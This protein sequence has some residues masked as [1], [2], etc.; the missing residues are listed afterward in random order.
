MFTALCQTTPRSPPLVGIAVVSR[1]RPARESQ[2]SE[3]GEIVLGTTAR[4]ARSRGKESRPSLAM[5]TEPGHR[6]RRHARTPLTR[7][8]TRIGH[9]KPCKLARIPV[10]PDVEIRDISADSEP[11]EPRAGFLGELIEEGGTPTPLTTF[12]RDERQVLRA[13]RKGL[14]VGIFGEPEPPEACEE[15]LGEGRGRDFADPKP[16]EAS[17]GSLG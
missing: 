17:T 16:P 15:F 13:H 6:Y 10:I 12:A 3:T 8:A 11:P 2:A 4:T 9:P 1:M 14:D 5:S 7:L